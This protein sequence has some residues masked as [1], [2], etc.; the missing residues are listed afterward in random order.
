VREALE[1]SRIVEPVDLVGRGRAVGD[2]ARHAHVVILRLGLNRRNDAIHRE[3]AVEVVGGDHDRALGVLQW[4]CEP[5]THDIA[6]N[7]EQ[8]DVGFLEQ[9]VLF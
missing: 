3:D 1:A 5:A 4:R 2:H 6:E 9:M 7:V 8:H